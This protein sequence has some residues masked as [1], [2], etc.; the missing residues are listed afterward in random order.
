VERA[1]ASSA[2]RTS[3]RTELRRRYAK[4][5]DVADFD[6]A[7]RQRIRDIVP[8]GPPRQ[9]LHRKNWEYGLLTQFL[10]DVGLSD[11][12]QILS[13]GAGHEEVLF[14]LANNAGRVV[15]TDIYGEG[16]FEGREAEATML[17]DPSAFAPYPFRTDRLDVRKMD[18]RELEF[19]SES[20][21]AVFT[22]SSIEHF[23]TFDDVSRA[24]SEIG[25]VLRPGG[26]AFVVTECFAST[27]L[28]DSRLLQT[29][30]RV[31]SLGR[32]FSQA[33]LRRRAIDVFTVEEIRRTIVRASG[34]DLMQELDLSLSDGSL[35]HVV[36]IRDDR[37]EEREDAPHVALRAERRI[38]PVPIRTGVWTSLALPLEK[39]GA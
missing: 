23:G 32:V 16:T 27:S 6:P 28:I 24:A 33:S 26:H 22:L 7:L 25:R 37:V 29:A 1:V 30:V 36:T 20:F 39:P 17:S 15:A 35:E 31:A 5:C 34:L 14:W 2:R 12:T 13:V 11:D 19:P 9:E 4:L 3:S 38:G 18:A 8:G 10:E 21:D